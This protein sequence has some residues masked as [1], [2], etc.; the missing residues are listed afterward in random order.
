MNTMEQAQKIN[1]MMMAGMAGEKLPDPVR[2]K[3][4]ERKRTAKYYWGQ[5]RKA[6]S[7]E[8]MARVQSDL[9]LDRSELSM[10]NRC[11]LYFAAKRKMVA[12][13]KAEEKKLVQPVDS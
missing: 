1:A 3:K 4:I 13:E 9:Y 12:L 6:D 10:R 5:I 8:E 2:E 11:A 7:I